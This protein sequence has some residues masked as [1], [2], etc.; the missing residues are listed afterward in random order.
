M[1]G[2]SAREKMI[3]RSEKEIAGGLEPLRRLL[4]DATERGIPVKRI[5]LLLVPLVTAAALTAGS[6]R[7]DFD[8]G[9]YTH[10]TCTNWNDPNTRV[11]PINYV[12][13]SWGTIERVWMQVVYHGLHTSGSSWADDGI[14]SDPQKFITHSTCYAMDGQRADGGILSSRNHFRYKGVHYDPGLGW[15]SIA[16]AHHEDL[17]QPPSPCSNVSPKHAV[18]SNDEPGGSGFNQG[19]SNVTN[20]VFAGTSHMSGS[21]QIWFGNTMPRRQCDGGIAWSDGYA[22]AIPLHQVNH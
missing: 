12:F 19:R 6:A 14:F 7:A 9:Y 13:F 2:D 5:M 20:K 18:D 15:T 4:K 17:I 22:R 1:T 21:Y 8:I 16:D 3:G 10:G 11:D